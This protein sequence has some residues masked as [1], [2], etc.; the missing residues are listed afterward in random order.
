[1]DPGLRRIVTGRLEADG[2]F[3]DGEGAL[4][5]AALAGRDSLEAQLRGTSVSAL[6]VAAQEA[7]PPAG[8]FLRAVGVEGFR[9]IGRA[10]TLELTPGPGLTLVVGRNGSGKSSLAE[11]LEVVLTGDSLRWKDRAAVWR[12]GWRN[13][14]HP[15]TSLS[16]TFLVE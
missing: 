9:G 1:M 7:P 6:P 11:A 14:H 15:T 5:L 4:V 12:D 2:A 16:A 13:L 8:A 10:Q 3:G